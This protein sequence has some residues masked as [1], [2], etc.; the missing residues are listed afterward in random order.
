[1]KMNRILITGLL[2]FINSMTIAQRISVEQY[3]EQYKDIAIIEMKRMGI[4]AAITLAQGILETE[5]GNSDLVKRSNNH[6]GIKC[7]NTWTGQSVSHTDDAVG[8]CFR[9]YKNPE[10]S[11]RDHSNF[12]RGNKRYDFLFDIAVTDYQKWAYGLK[13]AGYATNPRYPEI[14]IKNI[15]KYNLQQYTLMAAG[16]V[17]AFD[18]TKY[19]DDKDSIVVPP[20]PENIGVTTIEGMK[21]TDDNSLLDIPDQVI[22][23]N[24]SKCIYARKGTSLL[25]IA[26]KNNISLN[27]LLEYN[28][29]AEDGL[30][31]KNQY[32]YLQKKSKTGE[33]DY[34]IV[35]PGETMYDVAQK[36][37]IQ[38]QYLLNYN[39]FQAA[40]LLAEGTKLFLKPVPNNSKQSKTLKIHRVKEKEGL[41]AIAQKY[42]IT[43]E[44]L[45]VWNNLDNDELQIGQTLIVATK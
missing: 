30:L 8:E 38:L 14:L 10:E 9:A 36:N 20:A 2:F 27:K 45:R 13:K 11:Y 26:A 21:E 15:E 34:Y 29:L 42:K 33:Q 6:F 43:L 22:I 4:P 3:I 23:I 12:L 44:Q 25:V 19:T 41:Y 32:I 1:M 39:R 16:E 24:S 40:T 35:Q 5:S 37:G 18:E 7:K 31:S 17:P 28:E